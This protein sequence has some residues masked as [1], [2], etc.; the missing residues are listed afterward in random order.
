LARARA[1]Y[2]SIL[3]P[4]VAMLFS[5]FL[6]ADIA[7]FIKA[8]NQNPKPYTWVKSAHEILASV[9]GFCQKQ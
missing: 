7:A 9:K 5:T 2:T 8:H 6:E 1:A 3:V 4:I